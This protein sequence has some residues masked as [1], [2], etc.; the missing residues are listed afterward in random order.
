MPIKGMTDATSNIPRAICLG[1]CYG[2][3]NPGPLCAQCL[4]CAQEYV[5]SYWK[6]IDS[7][8]SL[9][10]DEARNVSWNT[11]LIEET[12]ARMLME[13]RVE[14]ADRLSDLTEVLTLIYAKE[15]NEG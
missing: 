12:R 4:K 14:M 15:G 11:R 6:A 2:K 3:A 13:N 1:G 10:G 5:A 7:G 8:V 9:S